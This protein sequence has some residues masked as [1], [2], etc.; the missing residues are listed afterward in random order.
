MNVLCLHLIVW[1]AAAERPCL[2]AMSV[3][4][5]RCPLEQSAGEM[6]CPPARS[7]PTCAWG[8]GLAPHLPPCCAGLLGRETGAQGTFPWLARGRFPLIPEQISPGVF[9]I[10]QVEELEVKET[11]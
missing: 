11:C 10:Q 8:W 9:G 3:P 1:K 7:R 2:G 4:G 5:L 6:G